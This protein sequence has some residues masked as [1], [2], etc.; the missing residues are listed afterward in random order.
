MHS[1]PYLKP[2][3]PYTKA[4]FL[5]SDGP[6][7][8]TF[9]GPRVYEERNPGKFATAEN[10]YVSN[11]PY[12]LTVLNY[13]D[14]NGVLI[15][16]GS[17]RM[18]YTDKYLKEFVAIKEELEQLEDKSNLKPYIEKLNKILA[19]I[20]QRPIPSDQQYDELKKNLS[21]FIATEEQAM[22]RKAST[23]AGYD[24]EFGL[25]RNFLSPKHAEVIVK[26]SESVEQTQSYQKYKYDHKE[27][28]KDKPSK[29]PL[30]LGISAIE[31]AKDIHP[32]DT[33]HVDDDPQYR[34]TTTDYTDA[35]KDHFQ[36]I[37][38][39]RTYYDPGYFSFFDNQYLAHML[40]I[41]LPLD[42]NLNWGVAM[43]KIDNTHLHDYAPKD[44]PEVSA[45]LQ[46]LLK[47]NFALSQLTNAI[48]SLSLSQEELEGLIEKNYQRLS[49]EIGEKNPLLLLDY[50]T[51]VAKIAIEPPKPGAD[52]QPLQ[53]L[54]RFDDA[55]AVQLQNFNF[56][57]AKEK[58]VIEKC[59]QKKIP[60]SV[61]LRATLKI[62]EQDSEK[63]NNILLNKMFSFMHATLANQNLSLDSRQKLVRDKL[64]PSINNMTSSRM[65]VI[66]GSEF[67]SGRDPTLESLFE[68]RGLQM[69]SVKRHSP[70]SH[71]IIDALKNKLFEL[72]KEEN[73]AALFQRMITPGTHENTI[74]HY[75]QDIAIFEERKQKDLTSSEK[76][77]ITYMAK[78]DI[79][80]PGDA[81]S[82][83]ITLYTSE[84]K[85]AP[86]DLP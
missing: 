64:I 62:D 42:P 48:T 84:Q 21:I 53:L 39:S 41:A 29:L 59:K 31:E 18:T 63:L 6:L 16:T 51:F 7:N 85:N 11:L 86:I 49:E 23:L 40:N 79:P 36:F 77:V 20:K 70:I 72:A 54:N 80:L 44:H 10:F 81:T 27:K 52:Q 26:E 43:L 17:Q 38:A 82:D 8:D 30:L 69:F 12:M 61:L 75:H 4:V 3:R 50:L 15:V 25:D 57:L 2:V 33:Y 22:K 14:A 9:K 74:L 60:Q 1:K 28:H 35:K 71:E 32:K 19:Q 37:L 24:R 58:E 73:D 78:N 76:E 66:F 5:D 46:S 13:L 67:L 45:D 65:L 83:V 55:K 68:K 34:D 56:I 47:L